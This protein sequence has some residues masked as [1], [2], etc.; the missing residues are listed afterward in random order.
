MALSSGHAV[1]GRVSPGAKHLQLL[2]KPPAAE[3]IRAPAPD[4]SSALEGQ[5]DQAA[6]WAGRNLNPHETRVHVGSFKSLAA[7]S[8]G[9][10]TAFKDRPRTQLRGQS[11]AVTPR[12]Q[13]P[14]AALPKPPSRAGGEAG[15]RKPIFLSR[16]HTLNGR[17]QP[18]TAELG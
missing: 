10:P 4:A 11:T 18:G 9:A 3:G 16:S 7:P 1:T 6:M 8:S 5:R 12:L 13:Q 2:P 15:S 17:S 14:L